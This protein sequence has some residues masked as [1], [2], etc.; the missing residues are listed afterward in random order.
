MISDVTSFYVV[1]QSERGLDTDLHSLST[2]FSQIF[3]SIALTIAKIQ[4]GI[5]MATSVN[6]CQIGN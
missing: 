3:K 1:L 6:V 2:I 4:R 5:L